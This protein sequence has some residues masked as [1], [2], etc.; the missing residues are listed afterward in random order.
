MQM[1]DN[2]VVI[3]V[4]QTGAWVTKKMNLAVPEQPEE[5]AQSAYECY[6][7]G[8]A[9]VHIHA[10]DARGEGTGSAEVFRDIHARIRAICPLV[11]Q[12]STGGSSNLTIEQRSECLEAHPEMASLNMGTL[13]RTFGDKVG[14]PFLNA[15]RDIEAYITRM[16][17]FGVKP[18][19]EIYDLSMI[20]EVQNLIDRGLLKTKPYNV[21]LILGVGHQGALGANPMYFSTYLQYLPHDCYFNT[22]G[23]GAFQIPLAALGMIHGGNA[24]VGLEDNI[25]YRKG[26]LAKSNAQLV[27]RIVRIARELGKEPATPDEARALFGIKPLK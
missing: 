19:M 27:A 22:I 17:Q 20:Q 6:N 2:K 25:Y 7:E 26:E 9:V 8:A 14:T 11:I 23:I 12:D 13:V 10:R 15:R 16:N 21:S 4:A 1:L 3:T 18:E 24:R 5:I